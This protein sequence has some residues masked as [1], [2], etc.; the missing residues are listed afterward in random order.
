MITKN[1]NLNFSIFDELFYKVEKDDTNI[2]KKLISIII[3]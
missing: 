3:S 1:I 2:T